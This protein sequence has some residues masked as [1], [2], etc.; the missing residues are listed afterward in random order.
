MENARVF[1]RVELLAQCPV[2]LLDVFGRRTLVDTEK[3]VVV[4]PGHDQR[5]DA[6]HQVDGFK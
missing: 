4:G 3:L 5:Q 6:E 1:V 2:G